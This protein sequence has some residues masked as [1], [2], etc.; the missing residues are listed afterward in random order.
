MDKVGVCVY[1]KHRKHALQTLSRKKNERLCVEL[2]QEVSVFRVWHCLVDYFTYCNGLLIL[3]DVW[4]LSSWYL[5]IFFCFFFKQ[6]VHVSWLFISKIARQLWIMR[7][8]QCK[9][10][11]SKVAGSPVT[12][13]VLSDCKAHQLQY[14]LL[15]PKYTQDL[16]WSRLKLS[17]FS[18]RESSSL[19][20]I[21]QR[22]RSCARL[23]SSQLPGMHAVG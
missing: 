5:H 19:I 6:R 8:K 2:W 16:I 13:C 1:Y 3:F 22:L 20:K 11:V 10:P 14:S 23:D 21:L 7:P 15:L 12:G 18:C 17:V 9:L 4:K